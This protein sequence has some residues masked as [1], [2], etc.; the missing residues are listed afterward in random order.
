[1]PDMVPG[2]QGDLPADQRTWARWFNTAAFQQAQY[3]RFGTS[4]RTGAFRLPGIMN[5]DFSAT[6]AFEFRETKSLQFRVEVFNLF[7]NF[8]PD[9]STVDT[10]LNSATFGS[11]GGGIRGITTRVIQLGA[12]LYF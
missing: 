1:R 8:N 11:V 12:K 6:K 2:Q 9:P 3:G 4:P 10:N 5:F 7:N